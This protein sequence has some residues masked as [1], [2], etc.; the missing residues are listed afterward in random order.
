MK[1]SSLLAALL[2]LG[3]VAPLTASAQV[4]REDGVKSI[5][6]VLFSDSSLGPVVAEWS[7]KSA[8]GEIVFASLDADIYRKQ[9]AGHEESTITA[10]ADTGGGGEDSHGT[11]PGMFKLSVV[12]AYGDLATLCEARRAAPPPGWQRDPRI[13]C[14]LPPMRSP[15]SYKVRVQ[16]MGAQGEVVQQEGYPFLLN[17][18]LRK[19][20]PSGTSIQSAIATSSAGGF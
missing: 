17:L 13:A 4:V 9:M 15:A 20:A 16:F 7:F 2:A 5:A 19:V 6:G 11:G 18:S 3:C 10:A 8:G 14:V 1:R 12:K